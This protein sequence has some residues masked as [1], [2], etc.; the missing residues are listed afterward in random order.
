MKPTAAGD[1]SACSKFIKK[2]NLTNR[3]VQTLVVSTRDREARAVVLEQLISVAAEC[4]GLRNFNAVMEI[5]SALNATPIHRLSDTWDLVKKS[6]LS[7]FQVGPPGCFT[8]L[9]A[10]PWRVGRVRSRV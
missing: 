2:F 4:R 8:R 10:A 6:A 5:T 3:W 7:T 1:S 9:P